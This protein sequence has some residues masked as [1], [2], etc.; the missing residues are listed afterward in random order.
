MILL[1]T[2]IL[3]L[4][5]ILVGKLRGLKTF[6]TFYINYYLIILYIIFISMGLNA[7]IMALI[8]SI[9]SSIISLFLLNGINKKIISSFISVLIVLAIISILIITITIFSNIQSFSIEDLENI[10]PY[11]FD[12]NYDMTKVIIGM[13]II[14]TV[15]SI[16]DT[17]ISISSSMNEIYENNKKISKKDL[18]KSGMNIGKDI[19]CTTINT[20]YFAF[21]GGFISFILLHYTE[22]L[23]YIINLNSFTK[24]VFMLLFCFVSSIIIIPI[25]AYISSKKLK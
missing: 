16:I 11:S 12:I 2:I 7:I 19:L 18:Y 22:S 4:L 8:L 17:S 23:S 14:C 20:L 1:L 9:L 5:L 13:F 10:I 15:G 6:F 25:T 24:D 3:F 21:F